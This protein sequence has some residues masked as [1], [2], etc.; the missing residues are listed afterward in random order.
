MIP[1]LFSA[2]LVLIALAV[3]DLLTGIYH[4]MTDRGWNLKHQVEYFRIHHEDPQ[5]MKSFD[6]QP[7]FAGVPFMLV[8]AW[9]E[10]SLILAMGSFLV[11]AQVPHYYVHVPNPPLAIRALQR[12][13]LCITPAYHDGHHC[14]DF[15]RNFCVLTGWGDYLLNPLVQ[16]LPKQPTASHRSISY[17]SNARGS[18]D[19]VG[20]SRK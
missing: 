5:S 6:W 2:M 4:V 19:V 17:A 9:L 12:V 7:M 1:F 14:G 11:L 15:D 10:S 20:I 13:G 18:S 3:V 8:G 16:L